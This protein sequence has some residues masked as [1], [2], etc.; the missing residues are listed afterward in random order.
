MSSKE[1]WNENP[2]LFW[3]Y[4]FSF[5]NKHKRE[6]DNLN[7]NAWL[8]GAYVYEA[9]SVALNNA[10]SKQKI[11]Y[12]KEPY[13]FDGKKE[14]TKEQQVNNAV[15]ELKGRISQIQSLWKSKEESSTTKSNKG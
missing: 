7:F 3:A 14:E 1:F 9:V 8:H 6:L 15:I 4:R 2:D 12:S 10:F 5:Y 13:D 11:K